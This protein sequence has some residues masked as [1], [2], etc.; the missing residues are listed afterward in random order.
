MKTACPIFVQA[1][2]SVV[3]AVQ[4]VVL[5]SVVFGIFHSFLA[6]SLA[7]K[8]AELVLMPTACPL[9]KCNKFTEIFVRR[10]LYVLNMSKT[11]ATQQSMADSQHCFVFSIPSWSQ[12]DKHPYADFNFTGDSFPQK[13]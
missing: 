5:F 1:A 12:T 13:S 8:E 10:R 4:R 9:L 2:E 7:V 6:G 11:P 3:L